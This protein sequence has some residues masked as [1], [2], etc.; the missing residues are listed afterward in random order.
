MVE[1]ELL[2]K[3]FK[4]VFDMD[5]PQE[6]VVLGTSLYLNEQ[7]K[8]LNSNASSITFEIDNTKYYKFYYQIR[9]KDIKISI[10]YRC[11]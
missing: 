1:N 3:M 7:V 11:S 2:L 10:Y 8:I 4:A 5:L 6:K 9:R